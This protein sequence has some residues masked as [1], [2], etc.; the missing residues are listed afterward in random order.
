M[1]W[2]YR[3]Y[4]K[5]AEGDPRAAK[6]RTRV[7]AIFV[8]LDGVF[9]MTNLKGLRDQWDERLKRNERKFHVIRKEPKEGDPPERAD[10]GTSSL[11]AGIEFRYPDGHRPTA[12]KP[13]STRADTVKVCRS[14]VGILSYDIRARGVSLLDEPVLREMSR[15]FGGRR[16]HEPMRFTK[17][18]V[19]TTKRLDALRMINSFVPPTPLTAPDVVRSE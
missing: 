16:N 8:I 17:P 18:E 12:S 11:F 13:V 19:E 15:K 1:A 14:V 9:V 2:L 10:P 4:V 3:E 5:V 7:G 6:T